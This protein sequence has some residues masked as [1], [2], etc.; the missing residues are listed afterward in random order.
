MRKEPHP[1]ANI[2]LNITLIRK[3]LK[4]ANKVGTK[5]RKIRKYLLV[6]KI[7]KGNRFMFSSW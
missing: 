2:F 3:E 1:H 5:G 4:E 6:G 7:I